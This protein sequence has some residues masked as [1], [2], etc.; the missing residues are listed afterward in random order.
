MKKIVFLVIAGLMT[1]FTFGQKVESRSISDFT[2]INA[3][4]AFEIT[5]VKGVA[6]SLTIETSEELMP[7]VRSEVENGVLH[8]YL[9]KNAPK[10]QNG[11]TVKTTVVMKDLDKVSLSGACKITAN[12]LFTPKSFNGD[13]S[14]SSDMTINISTEQLSI[15]TSGASK[16]QMKASVTGDTKMDISGSSD[17]QGELKTNNIDFSSSG[18]CKV[19]LTGSATDAIIDMS[20]SSDFN[21]G[22]FTVKTVTIRLSGSSDITVNA[23]DVLN[24]NSA[25][26]SSVS[27]KG[28]PAITIKSSGSSKVKKI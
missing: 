24:V 2:G 22:D 1:M 6:E 21:A 18:A 23:T 10:K 27:Y 17:I 9:E 12:D 19:D 8:L 3:S 5:A 20:G 7:Y 14:G 15:K 16:I 11:R 13:C 26:S 4:G 25:G 28:S